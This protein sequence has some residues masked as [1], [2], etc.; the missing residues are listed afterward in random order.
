M[1]L[2]MRFPMMQPASL[3]VHRR[4][5]MPN[6]WT[7]S[8]CDYLRLAVCLCFAGPQAIHGLILLL[9]LGHEPGWM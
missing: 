1:L 9:A 6:R 7:M 5:A 8:L 3:L 4:R 2:L